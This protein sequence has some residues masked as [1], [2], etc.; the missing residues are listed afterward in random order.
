MNL[1]T[2]H[3]LLSQRATLNRL[4][5]KT[6]P[7]EVIVRKG[8]EARLRQVENELKEYEG[9]SLES[10]DARLTFRGKP[11]RGARGMSTQFSSKALSNFEKA[12]HYV[13]ANLKLPNFP[14]SRQVPY[15]KDYELML[16]GI[17]RGS[18]GFQIEETSDQLPLKGQ[19]T[20]VG[21][22]LK[23][24]KAVLEASQDTADDERLAEEIG[25]TDNR[26]LKSVEDFLRHIADNEAAFTFEFRLDE[27]K[28]RDYEQVKRTAD[29]LS[30]DNIE[31]DKVTLAGNFD[32]YLPKSRRAE[33][34]VSETDDDFL[35]EFVGT[36]ITC[37]LDPEI[38]DAD[39]I[40]SNLN[41]S[42]SVAVRVRRVGSGRP[43][44]V[45]K[46][47]RLVG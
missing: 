46:A 41:K 14:N 45:I 1:Q 10:S 17:V 22:A 24:L 9:R 4:I 36:V 8:L 23:K 6:R 27:V 40:N 42:V 21:V 7:A 37:R 35:S 43:R 16:T 29:R 2:Y 28:Y 13:G 34:F 26:V 19:D 3:Y 47:W 15:K 11:V 31:E 5:A 38:E 33:F 32:G 30:K 44:F 20:D 12:V 25:D 39:S 18:F